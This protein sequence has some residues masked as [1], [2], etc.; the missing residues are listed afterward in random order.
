MKFPFDN[1]A[2]NIENTQNFLLHTIRLTHTVFMTSIFFV[3]DNMS[4]SKQKRGLGITT[5]AVVSHYFHF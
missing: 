1:Q 5:S 4:C 2:G 3:I